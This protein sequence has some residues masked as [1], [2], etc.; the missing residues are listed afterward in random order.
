MIE[1]LFE[2]KYTHIDERMKEWMKNLFWYVMNEM[3]IITNEGTEWEQIRNNTL[4][5]NYD[6]TMVDRILR[7][8]YDKL[9][10]DIGHDGFGLEF[11][12]RMTDGWAEGLCMLVL[13]LK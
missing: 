8:R 13:D 6:R 9:W 2:L 1:W 12:Y 10:F 7:F 4:H 11:W 5:E 3:I